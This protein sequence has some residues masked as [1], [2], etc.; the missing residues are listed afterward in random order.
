MGTVAIIVLGVVA[1]TVVSVLGDM[2]AK[3][4]QA[5]AKAKV[6][7]GTV[8]AGEIEALKNRIALLERRVEERDDAVGKLQDEVRFVSR[9]LEDK[10]GGGTPGN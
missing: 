8:P 3:I 7:E 6:A 9:M 10:S 1:I 5:K 2:A 4:A